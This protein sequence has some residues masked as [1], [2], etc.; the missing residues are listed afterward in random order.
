MIWILIRFCV[1]QNKDIY[2][3]KPRLY[4]YLFSIS[5]LVYISQKES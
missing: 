3:K 1:K 4:L 5:V 2:F